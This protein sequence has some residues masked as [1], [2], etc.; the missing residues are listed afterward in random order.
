MLGIF[1]SSKKGSV[2]RIFVWVLLGLLAVGLAGFTLSDVARGIAGQNVLRVGNERVSIEQY[3]RR[4]DTALQIFSRQLGIGLTMSQA[5]SFGLPDT[6]LAQLATETALDREAA[7]VGLS[8]G[9]EAVTQEILS[10]PGFGG[11]DG[12]DPETYRSALRRSGYTVPEYEAEVRREIARTLLEAGISGGV[13]MPAVAAETLLGWERE[14]RD[15][16]YLQL[17]PAQSA[18]QPEPDDT[19]LRAFY[20]ENRDTYVAPEMRRIAYAALTPADLAASIEPDEDALRAAYDAAG[21]RFRTPE[22]RIIDRLAFPDEAA[23]TAARA[24]IDAGEIDLEGLAAERGLDAG[25]IALGPVQP[26]DLD[27]SS[28]SAVFAADGPSI[29]GPVT[30]TLGPALFRVNAILAGRETS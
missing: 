6:V 8:A 16:S 14:A 20:A 18:P 12:F 26:R 7:A 3:T 5:R 21:E 28:R 10:R 4:L 13:V 11:A 29:V 22:R 27:A 23:A 17:T 15:F 9:D 30:T 24:R 2:G 19:T 1:R 25:A